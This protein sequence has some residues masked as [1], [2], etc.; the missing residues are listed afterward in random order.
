MFAVF[1]V[2]RQIHELLWYVTEALMLEAGS[3]VHADLRVAGD[4]LRA[5]TGMGP[6]ELE[7]L[8]VGAHRDRI[9]PLLSKASELVRA[10]VG[11]RHRDH[12]GA[13]LVGARL[14]GADLRGANLRGALLVGADLSGADLRLADLTGADLRGAD[15]GGADLTGALFLTQSQLASAKGDVMTQLSAGLDR[16]AHFTG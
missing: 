6:A 3:S 11:G 14:G 2:M 10:T 7:A 1:P 15:L 9:N 8:D 12:R 13:D 5:L 16:P 4:E